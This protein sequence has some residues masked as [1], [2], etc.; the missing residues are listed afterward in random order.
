MPGAEAGGVPGVGVPAVA[1]TPGL[2]VVEQDVVP[3]VVGVV[4]ARVAKNAGL[5]VGVRNE[6][7]G[8]HA[9]GQGEVKG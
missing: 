6:G 5:G 3:F 2:R 8:G 4:E 1:A 7:V 9:L